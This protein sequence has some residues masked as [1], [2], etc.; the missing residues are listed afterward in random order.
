MARML[1][2]FLNHLSM[3][4]IIVFDFDGVIVLGSERTKERCWFELFRSQGEKAIAAL[5][6]ARERYSQGKGSRYDIVGDVLHDLGVPKERMVKLV[7]AYCDEYGQKV[8]AG[9]LAEGIRNE[10]RRA[11]DFLVQRATLFINTTT[12][13]SAIEEI[14][15]KLGISHLFKGVYG[16]GLQGQTSKKTDTLHAISQ[17]ESKPIKNII[18]IGDGEGDH[19][20]AAKAGCRFIGIS[21]DDNHWSETEHEFSVVSS[22]SE[23]V[24]CLFPN[25][26][27]KNA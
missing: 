8:Q 16:Q 19:R 26:S 1:S 5:L 13:Q 10:D 22:V 9:I 7:K 25:F 18:F 2:E 11:L 20:A 3:Q 17:R 23:A 12:P 4:P 27:T 24:V 15:D 14:L 6:R 21:N